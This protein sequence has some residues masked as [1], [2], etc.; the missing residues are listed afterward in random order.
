MIGATSIYF[1]LVGVATMVI[2]VISLHSVEVKDNTYLY[3]LIGIG[4]AYVLL[5]A[6]LGY[7]AMTNPSSSIPVSAITFSLVLSISS[8]TLASLRFSAISDANSQQGKV[9]NIS[10]EAQHTLNYGLVSASGLTLL[11]TI[12]L[13]YDANRPKESNAP[14]PAVPS[15][16]PLPFY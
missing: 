14:S 4:G 8:I 11:L 9:M 15:L 6:G 12:V 10:V 16:A 1:L 2:S 3:S 13:L 7:L 5:G